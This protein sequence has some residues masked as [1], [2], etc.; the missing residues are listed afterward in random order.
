MS[1]V[2]SRKNH[3]YS[4]ER[5]TPL[6][7]IPKRYRKKVLLQSGGHQIVDTRLCYN[8]VPSQNGKPDKY[9]ECGSVAAY[10]KDFDPPK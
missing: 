9:V 1:V 7:E 2:E 5:V 6:D 8:W 4:S 3:P 10:A